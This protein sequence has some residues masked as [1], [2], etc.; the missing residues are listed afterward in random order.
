MLDRVFEQLPGNHRARIKTKALRLDSTSVKMHSDCT[1]TRW[2]EWMALAPMW[3]LFT[4]KVTWRELHRL[5]GL[6]AIAAA[7][8]RIAASKPAASAHQPA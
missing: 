4:Q 1:V 6:L 3:R 5:N 2:A 7:D 8:R